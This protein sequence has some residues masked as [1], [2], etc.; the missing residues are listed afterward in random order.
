MDVTSLFED[1][2]KRANM[3]KATFF[4]TYAHAKSLV[5]LPMNTSLFYRGSCFEKRECNIFG[6]TKEDIEPFE[7]Q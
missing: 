7:E 1:A 2:K 4:A 3:I 5:G 6:L